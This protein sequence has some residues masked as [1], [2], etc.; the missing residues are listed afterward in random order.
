[1]RQGNA[2]H[3]PALPP[4]AQQFLP[5]GRPDCGK[6]LAPFAFLGFNLNKMV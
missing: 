3:R 2:G 5:D 4:G 1:M 6:R